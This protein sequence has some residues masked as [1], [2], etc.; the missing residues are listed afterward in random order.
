MSVRTTLA[1]VFSVITGKAAEGAYRPGPYTLARTGGWLSADVGQ[2]W[3]FWQL[4]HDPVDGAQ[5]AM[6]EACTAAYARTISVCP[7]GHFR[8]LA[9][10]G[11]ER[12]TNSA[13][14]RILKAPNDYQTPAEFMADAVRC[15]FLQG[16]AYALGLRN[17]RYEVDQLH[18]MDPRQCSPVVVPETGDI[19]YRLA[20]NTVIAYRLRAAD[21]AQNAVW[22]EQLIVPARD[23]LHF[24][25]H[26]YSHARPPYPLV[27]QTPLV[28]AYPDLLMAEKIRGQQDLFYRNQARPSAVLTTDLNLS[29][30]QAEELRDRWNEQAK[31]LHQGGVP[32][33]SAGLKVMPW[34]SAPPAKDLQ[35]AELLQMSANK[36]ALVYGVPL[37]ILG[38]EN[39]SGSTTEKLMRGWLSTSLGP[40]INGIEQRYDA[41]FNLKGDEFTEFNTDVL[42]RLEP[43]ENIEML[44]RA[45]QGGVYSVNEARARE[46]LPAV[47]YGFEPR[48]QQQV[49]PL[50]AAAAIEPSPLGPAPAVPAAPPA[51]GVPSAPPARSGQ[52]RIRKVARLTGAEI[53]ADINRRGGEGAAQRRTGPEI[54]HTTPIGSA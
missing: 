17:S 18:L 40:T 54:R 51:A 49:V 6:I 19:F 38:I 47:A 30:T 13:L 2:F 50:S 25:L 41:F 11:K 10:G 21:A 16:N 28:A 37:S 20:G 52:R 45:V 7:G 31:G 24:R 43:R 48:V 22:R 33:L 35:I 12:I 32:I 36:I 53:E 26:A 15:L 1:R 34:T 29:R 42:L 9:N 46:D 5:A 44:V 8:K 14:A 39:A 3:N 27:G 4:G 23:V